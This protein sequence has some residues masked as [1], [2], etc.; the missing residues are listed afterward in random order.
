MADV[1]DRTDSSLTIRRT[2]PA[3]R[4]IV[5]SAWTT[6]QALKQWHAPAGWSN[7]VVEVDLRVGGRYRLDIQEPNGTLHRVLG[8]YLEVDAPGRLVYTWRWETN[9]AFGETVVTVEFHDRGPA[10]DIVLVHA[11]NVSREAVE[12][13]AWGWGACLDQFGRLHGCA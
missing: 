11:R 5:F 2:I 8:E 1:Q 7:P 6:P 10:T 9:P 12:S 3:A 13:H 4:D